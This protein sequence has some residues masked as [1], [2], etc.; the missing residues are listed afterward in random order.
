MFL[1]CQKCN[2]RGWPHIKLVC[3]IPDLAGKS[4]RIFDLPSE[5]K[6]GLGPGVCVCVCVCVLEG[7]GLARERNPIYEN[8]M[9]VSQNGSEHLKQLFGG[10]RD[11]IYF[12]S[13]FCTLTKAVL[14]F[15][16]G[17]ALFTYSKSLLLCISVWLIYNVVLVLGMQQS[18]S[19][20]DV[21]ILSQSLF[22]Y[23]LL[24]DT[25]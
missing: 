12:Q 6:V 4:P 11:W 10:R 2:S 20:M 1:I 23:K 19:V 5:Q 13:L 18:D 8:W 22:P 25:E 24:K 7:V 14:L 9:M 15:S 21:S 3:S 16:E 17:E